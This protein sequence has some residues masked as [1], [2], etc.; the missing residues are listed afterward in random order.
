MMVLQQAA[1]NECGL[2]LRRNKMFRSGTHG[3]ASLF[4]A[5]LGRRN[6]RARYAAIASALDGPFAIRSPE[7]QM[8]NRQLFQIDPVRLRDRVAFCVASPRYQPANFRLRVLVAYPCCGYAA[9]Q[10]LQHISENVVVTQT[11]VRIPLRTRT[12]VAPDSDTAIRG[13]SLTTPIRK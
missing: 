12:P 3:C 5:R 7:T 11:R 1:V 13:R 9:V 8:P 6:Y 4:V 10:L 2:L